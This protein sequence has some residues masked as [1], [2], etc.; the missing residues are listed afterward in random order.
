[1]MKKKSST[2]RLLSVAFLLGSTVCLAFY[3]W[4][5]GT[6]H[7]AVEDREDADREDVD[8]EDVDREVVN[9]EVVNRKRVP[10]WRQA[11]PQRVRRKIM[12]V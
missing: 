8:R 2:A 4:K 1:M 12:K 11:M 6:V 5:E 7:P 10:H 9:R 3:G